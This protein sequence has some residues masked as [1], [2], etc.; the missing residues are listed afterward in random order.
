MA[1]RSKEQIRQETLIDR[2]CNTLMSGYRINIMD[3]RHL[4][5]AGKNAVAAGKTDAEVEA[6]IVAAR[7][8]YAEKAG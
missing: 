1:R 7:D 5:T 8:K 4:S 3:M 2:L 6:A